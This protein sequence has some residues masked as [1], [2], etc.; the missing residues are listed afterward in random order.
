ML[1]SLIAWLLTKVGDGQY[2][3]RSGRTFVGETPSSGV[4]TSRT[5]TAGAGLTGGGDLS[6]NRTLDVGAGDGITVNANDI[7]VNTTVV[8]TTG[9][10]SIGGDKHF[11]GAVQIDGGLNMFS[12]AVIN[13][14]APATP[15]EPVRFGDDLNAPGGYRQVL[16]FA[17]NNIAAG[18]NATYTASSPQQAGWGGSPVPVPW[19]A[20]RS[21]SIMALSASLTTPAAGSNLRVAVY[22]NGALATGVTLDF[23]MA[24]GVNNSNTWAKDGA[25]RVFAAGD[26]ILVAVFTSSNWSATTAGIGVAVEV[27]S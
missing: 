12:T 8:R 11:T 1:G 21:G 18:D 24:G 4:P 16:P 6:T 13:L 2:L 7:A 22:I 27:E 23:T 3:K 9:S 26:R 19:V 25:G 20:P 10:Q 15:N 5:I 14:P 17:L